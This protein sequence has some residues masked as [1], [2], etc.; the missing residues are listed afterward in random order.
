MKPMR[1]LTLCLLALLTLGAA[2]V[3]RGNW[4]ATVSQTAAGSHVVGNPNAP[5]KLVEYMSYTCHVCA[6]FEV[7][8]SGPLRLGYVA[9][10]KVSW[11]I[12]NYIRDP[13]D[14][15]VALITSC[16]PPS[17]FFLNT[18][19]FLRTQPRWLAIAQRA[20][21]AQQQRWYNGDMP[22]RRRAIASDL[23]FYTIAATRG[24]DRMA[25]DRCLADEALARRIA[26]QTVEGDKAGVTGTPSFMLNGDLLIGTFS[27]ATLRT[28]LDARL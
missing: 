21:K 22:A 1:L 26:A 25:V 7:E 16:G 2:P 8:G 20:T 19:V 17:A 13:I 24:L 4:N 6:E 3:Q 11:E 9:P 12:R 14:G 5:I 28:H 18:A 15:T 10:G 23:G 27:W